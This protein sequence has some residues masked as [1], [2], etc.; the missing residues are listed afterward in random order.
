MH[1]SSD[2]WRW[3]REQFRSREQ[4]ELELIISS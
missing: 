4:A 3:F 2:V 1:E